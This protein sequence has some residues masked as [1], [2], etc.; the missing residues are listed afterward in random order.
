MIEITKT[1]NADTRTATKPLDRD[2]LLS[3][4]KR[5]YNACC[6]SYALVF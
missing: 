2:T 5:T 4:S 6:K 3:S 1:P